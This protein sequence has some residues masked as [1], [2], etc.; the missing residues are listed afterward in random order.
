[1]KNQYAGD[2]H[3][4]RKLGILRILANFYEKIGVCWLLTNNDE[5][6][7]GEFRKYLNDKKY[8]RKYK[9]FDKKLYEK[10]RGQYLR[11]GELLD[12]QSRNVKQLETILNDLN[13]GIKVFF[14]SAS[15]CKAGR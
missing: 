12:K 1:M 8:N 7:D 9:I 10:L 13:K 3:D 6:D 4:F 2:L 15:F 14:A 5:R 11:N